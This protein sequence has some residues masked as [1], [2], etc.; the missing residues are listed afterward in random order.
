MKIIAQLKEKSAKAFKKIVATSVAQSLIERLDDYLEEIESRQYVTNFAHDQFEIYHPR[1]ET[2]SQ[3][4]RDEKNNIPRGPFVILMAPVRK[5]GRI[6]YHH[7]RYIATD[8]YES[9]HDNKSYRR[10]M[11]DS[12]DDAMATIW[13]FSELNPGWLLSVKCVA[14]VEIDCDRYRKYYGQSIFEPVPF[15]CAKTYITELYK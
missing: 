6:G 7:N 3:V 11:F 5:H 14:I 2:R 15:D 4:E 10:Q 13:Q 9:K 8:Y 1:F 12:I